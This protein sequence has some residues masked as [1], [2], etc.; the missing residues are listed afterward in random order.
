[1]KKPLLNLL[2]IFALTS[3]VSALNAQGPPT[4]WKFYLAFEDA[5]GAKDTIWIGLDENGTVGNLNPDL[6]EVPVQLD[7]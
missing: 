1:M 2:L 6:G 5:T 3:V 7:Y 4:Q